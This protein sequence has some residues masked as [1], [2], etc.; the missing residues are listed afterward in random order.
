MLLCFLP[1]QDSTHD[2]C[3]AK[4]IANKTNPYLDAAYLRIHAN[5]KTALKCIAIVNKLDF[6]SLRLPFGTTPVPAKY[7]TI[8]E[9]AIDLGND[10]L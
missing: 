5:A 3:N 2:L 4:Q 8:S 6:L 9:A 1:T 7:T 10:L